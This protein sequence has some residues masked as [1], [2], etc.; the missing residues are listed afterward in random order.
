MNE[1]V[2]FALIGTGGIAQSYAQAFET[3]EN[4]KLVA[5]C[6]VRLDAAKAMADRF[7]CGAFTT[8]QELIEQTPKLDAVLI[9]TPPNTHEDMTTLFVKAGL[10]VLCEKPFTLTQSSARRMTQAAQDAG[11]LITMA[12]KFRYVEDVIKAKSLVTS[13]ILGEIILFENAF[14]ARVD[15][16]N[17]WNSNPEIA[18]GGVL[19]DNGTHSVDLMRYFLGPLGEVHCVEGKRTQ[20]LA[21]EDTVRV[22]VRSTSGVMGNVDLSWSIN[23][24][25]DWY[26]NIYGS[27][28]TVQI[29]WK[30]SKYR[31][32]TSKD[33]IVFGKGYNKVQAFRSEIDNFARAIRGEEM[34]LIT[35]EDAI[36]SVDAIEAAYRSLRANPWAGLSFR[37]GDLTR[38]PPPAKTRT[39]EVEVAHA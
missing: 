39:D 2:N 28:G 8:S 35:A 20:G 29:G 38:T 22:F 13:G 27:L 37:Q 1:P 31:Q 11:V 21:V 33:W 15:M 26:V 14:T 16:A 30:E 19:I 23:K 25:L 3:S 36:A 7:R 10:H 18:G 34:L 24:E 32:A 5:V 17:R 12:S 9:C 6:D 4:A